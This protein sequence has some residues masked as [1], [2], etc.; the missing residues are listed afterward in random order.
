MVLKAQQWVN[1]TYASVSGYNSCTED[2]IT[3]W[4]T[5]YSLTR[6]LQ[7]EL[8]IVALSDNFGPTTLSKLTAYGPVGPDSNNMNMRIIA[9]AALYCKG[10]SG[11]AIDGAFGSSTQNGLIALLW[12]IGTPAVSPVMP[13]SPKLFKA[14]LTMDAYVLT[15]GGSAAIQT[16]QRWLN[17]AYIDRGQFFIGPC[18]GHFSRNV[19]V[20][21]VLAIQYQMGMTDS[22]VTGYIGPG[23]RAG[24]QSQAYVSVSSGSATWIRLFQCAVAFNGYLNEWGDSGGG[25]PA[26][27]ATTV[28][29]FQEFCMLPPNGAGDYQTWMSL[30]VST[31]D[32]D[33]PGIAFDCMYPLN[34][35][36]IVAIKNAGYRIAG[37]YLTGG[38][39]K[40]LT[41]SE[42]A[43]ITDN[44]MSFFPIYQEYGNAVQYF[45]Y[46][47][48]YAAGQAACQAAAEFGIP[49][50]TVIYFSVDYD[51]IDTEITNFVIPHFRGIRDAVGVNQTTYAIGVY[52]CRNVCIRL[53]EAGLTTRSF[54]SG[55]ST[56][57]S[58]NLGFPLPRNWAFDQIKN[59][60]IAS[61]QGPVEIDNDIA[62]G[63]DLGLSSVTR[64]GDPNDGFYTY[65]I[66]LEARAGQW[67]DDGHTT[68]SRAELVAQYLRK[69]DRVNDLVYGGYSVSNDVFGEYDGG[70]ID[71]ANGY[72]GKPDE[73][74][75]RDPL[76]LW[77]TD[78]YHFGASFGAVQTHSIPGDK[79]E[80]NLVDFGSWGGDLLSI[81]GQCV[82]EDVPASQA[83][84]FAFER[85][86]ST[87]TNTFF[88][89]G[90]YFADVDAFVIG[91]RCR[92][93]SSL[94]LSDLFKAYYSD[95]SSARG[96]FGTFLFERFDWDTALTAA[97]ESMMGGPSVDSL[98]V[99]RDAFWID[100][101]ASVRYP[102]CSAVPAEIRSEVA[103]A[104]AARALLFATS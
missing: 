103:R 10:Y 58:G 2:G 72:L 94:L 19:Q 90:D 46:D 43:L 27:L 44:G 96:R 88:D 84:E 100:Q 49:H 22:Q 18:D 85:I 57:Y 56:G 6:A 71:F 80:V 3:G 64:P 55:M 73:T 8:G 14:L 81:L 7:H 79:R 54:V 53:D 77:D 41:S 59:L 99:L 70:F 82:Q 5:M 20:A 66:W 35:T 39:N 98:E 60:T 12:N 31:G 102:H 45:S 69:R 29:R 38:T 83:Y 47:Q 48:G 28:R 4:A 74:P 37:R 65:L 51:A 15:S 89:R 86:A 11:G 93:D 23:T 87:G 50:G 1:A 33:R 76:Y 26:T 78:V 30:L 75:L 67:R 63:R 68:Y 32:P 40:R 97:A 16:C 101:F 104:F 42:I 17:G 25:Y 95:T 9:E 62:S 13:V 36:T 61:D 52:G 91:L 34:S 92:N 21:L 24:L